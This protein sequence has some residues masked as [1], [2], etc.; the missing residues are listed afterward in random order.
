MW[1]ALSNGIRNG[2][3][4]YTGDLHRMTGPPFNAP[5][6]ASRVAHVKVGAATLSFDDATTGNLTANVLGVNIYKKITRFEYASPVPACA[7][8]GTPGALP[9]YQDLWWKS[10]AHSESGWGVFITHQGDTLFVA[11]F[12]YAAD[13]RGMWLS[14]SNVARTGNAT[15]SGALF[16]GV[17]PPYTAAQW[18]RSKVAM[19]PVGSV[20]LSFADANN[21]TMTYTVD[22]VTQAKTLTRHVFATPGTVCR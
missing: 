1:L 7:A 10:P 5:F 18:D 12:T 6:D 2:D 21:A 16:R 4:S 11:I 22:T 17:G 9:N 13:G 14:G 19:A 20:S 3:N 8:A 15:Y